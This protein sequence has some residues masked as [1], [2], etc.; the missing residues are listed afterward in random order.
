MINQIKCLPLYS[1]NE[2]RTKKQA[3]F[4]W[5]EHNFWELVGTRI[6]YLQSLQLG[7]IPIDPLVYIDNDYYRDWVKIFSNFN[8]WQLQVLIH[9]FGDVQLAAYKRNRQFPF[10]NPR[11]L[12]V[13]ICHEQASHQFAPCISHNVNV[14][15]PVKKTRNTMSETLKFIRGTLPV[16]LMEKM[17][18]NLLNAQAWSDFTIGAIC[19]EVGRKYLINEITGRHLKLPIKICTK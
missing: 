19:E 18:D 10:P 6:D 8:F 16:N 9:H 13:Y 12:L 5:G 1:F 11:T 14:G 4:A 17:S 3:E 2:I 7:Y 15:R